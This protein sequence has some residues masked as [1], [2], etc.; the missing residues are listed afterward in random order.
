MGKSKAASAPQPTNCGSEE[1]MARQHTPA[2]A[3][4]D[5][6]NKGG[7]GRESRARGAKLRKARF[8]TRTREYTQ[9]SEGPSP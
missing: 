9:P 5:G 2:H 6:R 1:V 3:D 4:T 8:H 7:Q